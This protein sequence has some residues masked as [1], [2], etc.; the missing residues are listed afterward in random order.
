[1]H[2]TRQISMHRLPFTN[3]PKA[4]LTNLQPYTPITPTT[5]STPH[6][7]A[8]TFTGNSQIQQPASAKSSRFNPY[9]GVQLNGHS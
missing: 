9:P 4:Q 3:T 8:S 2:R 6:T 5:L 7:N 1:M